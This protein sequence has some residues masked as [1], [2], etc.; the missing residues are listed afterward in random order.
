MN[1]GGA[2]VLERAFW[3]AMG[4]TNLVYKIT[5]DWAGNMIYC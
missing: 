4:V 2:S 1:K 5:R 3:T